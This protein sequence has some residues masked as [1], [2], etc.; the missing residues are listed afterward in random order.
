[1]K[2]IS[3]YKVKDSS[4]IAP[5]QPKSFVK[6]SIKEK[7]DGQRGLIANEFIRNGSVIFRDGGVVVTSTEDVFRDKPYA[8]IIEEGLFLVPQDYDNLHESCFMNHGCDSNVARIGGLI[9]IA[10]KDIQKGEELLI[11]YAPLIADHH[12]RSWALDCT[13]GDNLCRKVITSDDW[14]DPI[15]AKKF[16]VE[17]LPH[18]QRKIATMRDNF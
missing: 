7:I 2:Y 1:M 15:L 10:K 18:I 12:L 5:S 9:W 11:D 16:W 4:L 14:K 17:W 13:C 8:V 3:P 6:L